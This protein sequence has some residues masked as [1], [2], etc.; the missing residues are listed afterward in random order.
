MEIHRR[1]RGNGSKA[2]RDAVKKKRVERKR[3]GYKTLGR[4]SVVVQK[5]MFHMIAHCAMWQHSSFSKFPS[6]LFSY[7]FVFLLYTIQMRRFAQG[8]AFSKQ[9]ES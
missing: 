8:K 7:L 9:I 5:V 4:N 6:P 1:Q 3:A 2:D